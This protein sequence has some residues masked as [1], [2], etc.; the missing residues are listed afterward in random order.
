MA[1]PERD[2]MCGEEGVYRVLVEIRGGPLGP[3]QP[4]TQIGEKA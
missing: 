3:L 4:L 1:E 2:P